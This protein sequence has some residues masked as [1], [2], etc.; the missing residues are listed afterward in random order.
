MLPTS[1][2]LEEEEVHYQLICSDLAVQGN[3]S[4]PHKSS[5]KMVRQFVLESIIL[6]E[7]GCYK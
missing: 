5:V 6:P 3:N 7:Y 2:C 4:S 1:E